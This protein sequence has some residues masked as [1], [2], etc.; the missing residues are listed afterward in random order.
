MPNI[1]LTDFVDFV[2]LNGTPRQTKVRQV[3]CRGN[4]DPRFD[5]WRQL[6]ESII[7][8][9]NPDTVANKNQY[10]DDFLNNLPNEDKRQP[11]T[12]VIDNYKRFLGRKQII[13]LE[14]P[15]T[16]WTHQTLEVRVNPE[17]YL[18]INEVNHLYKLYF[19]PDQLAKNRID[20]ML[21]LMRFALPTIDNAI[22]Y[23]FFD[24]QNN[25]NIREANPNENLM[26]L[27]R[28]EATAFISLWDEIECPPPANQEIP[29]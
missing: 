15:R 1:S 21:A 2:L 24:G 22:Y 9:H 5:F 23:C 28:A 16:L 11:Y 8:F 3:K 10:F 4:Y 18:Q 6:R 12:L 27:L 26:A 14:V 19:K 7:R 13:Q 17:L 29:F 25:R 20:M